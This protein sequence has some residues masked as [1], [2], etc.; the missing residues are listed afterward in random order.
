MPIRESI[1]S[2][3]NPRVKLA[4]KLHDKPAREREKLFVIDDAR[5]LERAI[6]YGFEVEFVL[7]TPTQADDQDQDLIEDIDAPIYTVPADILE[8]ASYRQNPG[9]LV[10]VLR[11]KPR[12]DL[13][14]LEARTVLVLVD[15]RKPGN[16]GALLRTADAAGVGTVLLVDTAL[17][18]YN[19]NIIRSSTGACFLN[20][21]YTVKS[22][23][24]LAALKASG[25]HCL[26]GHLQGA[27]N[28]YDVDLTQKSALVLGT[29]DIGLNELWSTSC[30]VRVRIPM[31]GHVTDS[32]NVSVSGAILMY[33]ALRQN[34]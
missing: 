17:D 16:I 25:Y 5:D 8:K 34:R 31:M 33:E 4:Q 22:Q 30:D 3:Q 11:Q 9:G 1:T 19:P 18:L 10:A 27:T 15:L 21:I 28:L 13:P 26:A 6:A 32:L 14:K 2:F 12:Q 24:A 20:T 7:Y 29:E 23:P